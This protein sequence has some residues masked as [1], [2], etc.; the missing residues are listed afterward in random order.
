MKCNVAVCFAVECFNTIFTASYFKSR[1]YFFPTKTT[2]QLP[3]EVVMRC[4]VSRKVMHCICRHL[5][6]LIFYMEELRLLV[7][8]YDEVI[9]RYYV[10]FMYGYDSVVLNESVQN[11]SVSTPSLS[12]YVDCMAYRVSCRS[13]QGFRE[14]KRH[15]NHKKAKYKI[16][17]QRQLN[18]HADCTA[19]LRQ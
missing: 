5:G 8:R 6:E 16:N 14:K 9:Q 11:L 18:T 3:I 13:Y 17:A 2:A 15:S 7:R 10:Q 12:C 1:S 4:C 19:L